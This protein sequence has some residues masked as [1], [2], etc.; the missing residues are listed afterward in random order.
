MENLAL[1]ESFS[2]FKDE[3]FIDRVT[4]MSILEEVFRNTLKRKYGDDDNF[5]IIINPDKGDLEIWRNRI[6]VED[7]SVEDENQEIVF[8][9]HKKLNQILK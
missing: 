8:L 9:K 6:V 4:L 1:I 5:D 3:K 2:E 7:G